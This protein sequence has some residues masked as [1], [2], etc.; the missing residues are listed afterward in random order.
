MIKTK[1]MDKFIKEFM[2]FYLQNPNVPITDDTFYRALESYGFSA[3]EFDNGNIRDIFPNLERKFAGSNLHV[4]VDERQTGFLQFTSHTGSPKC[5]KMY[6]SF[7]KE[8]MEQATTKIFSFI[9]EHNM[10]CSSKIAQRVRS[11]SIVIRLDDPKDAKKVLN[12]INRDREL[13]KYHKSTNPFS[14]KEGIVGIGYDNMLSYNSVLSDLL[15]DYFNILRANNSL[16]NASLTNFSSYVDDFYNRTFI[17]KENLVEFTYSNMYKHF[18]YRLANAGEL[19]NNLEQ[20]IRVIKN[21]ASNDL[22]KKKY[23]DMYERFQNDGENIAYFNREY[24]NQLRSVQMNVLTSYVNA[25]IQKYG[26]DKVH[27]YLDSYISGNDN[28]ITSD[29]YFRQYF[30]KYISHEDLKYLVMG[31]SKLFV[32]SYINSMSMNSSIDSDYYLFVSACM[33]T[34]KK[35]GTKQATMAIKEGMNGNYSYFTNN[36]TSKLRDKLKSVVSP[37]QIVLFLNRTITDPDKTINYDVVIFN[38]IQ[39]LVDTPTMENSVQRL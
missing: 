12:F 29:N 23:F 34:A 25:A 19:L 35:Y 27:L 11:D 5:V 17:T 15:V 37:E 31:D 18:Q 13:N 7:P 1:E 24:G 36:G 4:Y 32:E 33:A 30:M 39:S 10:K 22:N 20:I 38:F 14:L 28:A 21:V 8:Y 16:Q 6:L 3:Q 2:N 9:S 26:V